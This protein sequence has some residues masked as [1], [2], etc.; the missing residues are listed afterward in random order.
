MF[1]FIKLNTISSV[2]VGAYFATQKKAFCS[3]NNINFALVS[4]PLNQKIE[5]KTTFINIDQNSDQ[6]F[7]TKTIFIGIEPINSFT[8]IEPKYDLTYTLINEEIETLKIAFD[9]IF[10]K[11]KRIQEKKKIAKTKFDCLQIKSGIKAY[12]LKEQLQAVIHEDDE[13]HFEMIMF[14][15][16]VIS[17]YQCRP[18]SLKYLSFH[19]WLE[20]YD[21][22]IL[23]FITG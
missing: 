13:I 10:E 19:Q 21:F 8:N 4:K 22:D 2:I 1:R 11:Y 23:G 16:K 17:I 15:S 3:E 9:I 18:Q 6:N 14:F 7:E 12:N 20:Y 5:P